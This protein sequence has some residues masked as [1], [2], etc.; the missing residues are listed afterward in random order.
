MLDAMRDQPPTYDHNGN[1]DL[2]QLLHPG[3]CD[4]ER[5]WLRTTDQTYIP[6][7]PLNEAKHG[8]C[9]LKRNHFRWN[10]VPGII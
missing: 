1:D 7:W 8:E 4:N 2:E 3:S 10:F 5:L 6:L 9:R